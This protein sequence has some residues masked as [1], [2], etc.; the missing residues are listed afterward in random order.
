MVPAYAQVTI[1]VSKITC[2]QFLAYSVGDPKDIATWLSG[3]YHGKQSDT[4]LQTQELKDKYDQLKDICYSSF[5]TPIMQ[6]TE[7]IFLRTK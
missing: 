7:R 1:D 6:I 4:T 3:Y 2:K 5:D